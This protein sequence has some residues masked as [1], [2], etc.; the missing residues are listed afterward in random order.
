MRGPFDAGDQE[1]HE[2]RVFES[3]YVV[4]EGCVKHA[5]PATDFVHPGG[6]ALGEGIDVRDQQHGE[7]LHIAGI[8]VES[9]PLFAPIPRV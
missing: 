6:R 8:A 2:R 5:I 9:V 1:L 3:R 4:S 7:A